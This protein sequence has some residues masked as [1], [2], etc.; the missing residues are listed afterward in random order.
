M[1]P[2][3]AQILRMLKPKKI[4]FETFQHEPVKTSEEAAKVRPGYTLKQG[5]KAIIFRVKDAE[6]RHF[7]M[8]VFPADK[9]FDNEKLKTLLSAKDIRF[10]TKEEL[11]EIT[12]GVET[13]AVP[14]FGHLFSL[15]VLADKTLFDNEKI[16]FNAGDRR[17]SVALRSEDYLALENPRVEDIVS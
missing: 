5:A 6:G 17:F 9:R 10:A 4:W 12:N 16:V 7:H 3:T 2:V 15:P 1:H 13:G 14:P 11:V 8:V